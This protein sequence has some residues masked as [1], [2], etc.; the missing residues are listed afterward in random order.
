M[1]TSAS[2]EQLS[3]LYVEDDERLR[4]A[5]IAALGA[6][7]HLVGAGSAAEASARLA[8]GERFSLLVT[9]FALGHGEQDGLAV[10]LEFRATHKREPILVLSSAPAG[11]A[12]TEGSSA[13]RSRFDRLLG[14]HGASFLAKPVSRDALSTRLSELLRT[15]VQARAKVLVVEDD[16]A[17]REALCD[18]LAN[19][20]YEALGAGTAAAAL[21]ALGSWP[22]SLILLD[23]MLPDMDGAEFRR[24]QLQLESVAAIPVVVISASPNMRSRTENLK[25]DS[26]LAKPMDAEQ[27]LRIVQK[28]A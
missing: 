24:R 20:G 19:E 5:V 22:P 2:D 14:L 13:E 25:I 26:Y 3:I 15:G 7:W 12:G 9:D 27:L 8:A 1:T 6:S 28:L 23:L 16:T 17:T 10:A 21:E 18:L 11:S 4:R